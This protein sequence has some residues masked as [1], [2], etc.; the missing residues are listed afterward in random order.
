M[1]QVVTQL[2][3]EIISLKAQVADQTGTVE[4][5]R[6]INKIAIAQVR[7]ETTSLI[8]VKGPGKPKEF[9]GKGGSSLQ[10]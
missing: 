10:V 7:K 9:I 6:A 2:Q 8:D 5:V 4:A 3:Q 1:E